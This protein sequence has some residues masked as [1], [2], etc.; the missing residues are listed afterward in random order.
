MKRIGIKGTIIPNDYKDFYDWFGIENTCPNDV[1]AGI[2]EAD[3][4]DIVFEINSGGGS[5][6]AGSEIYHAI[7]TMTGA[8]S[9]RLAGMRSGD[10]CC[11]RRKDGNGTGRAFADDERGNLD[12]CRASGRTGIRGRDRPGSGAVQRIL[13]NPNNRTNR[14]SKE[15]SRRQ[16]R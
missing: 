16:G 11:I 15:R 10:R 13:R 6:F 8:R 3:G 2:T 4:D 14:Q 7:L 1:K 12:Q 9:S 5:I